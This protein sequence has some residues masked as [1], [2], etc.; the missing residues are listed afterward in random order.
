MGIPA[1]RPLFTEPVTNL[2]FFSNTIKAWKQIAEMKHNMSA[3]I[4]FLTLAVLYTGLR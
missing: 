2:D 4:L 1:I 3:C